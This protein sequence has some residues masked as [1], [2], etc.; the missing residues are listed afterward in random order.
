M[1]TPTVRRRPLRS[2][3]DN[4]NPATSTKWPGIT[5]HTVYLPLFLTVYSILELVTG[6]LLLAKLQQFGENEFVCLPGPNVVLGPDQSLIV[7][8][9]PLTIL[10]L[11]DP[12]HQAKPVTSLPPPFSL[13]RNLGP[14]YHV[15]SC[16]LLPICAIVLSATLTAMHFRRKG[17][18]A[19]QAMLGGTILMAI[20]GVLSWSEEVV[21]LDHEYVVK[22]WPACGVEGYEVDK[23]WGQ[24]MARRTLENIRE[25][26]LA[27]AVV[28]LIVYAILGIAAA[29]YARKEAKMHATRVANLPPTAPPTSSGADT[30]LRDLSTTSGSWNPRANPSTHS[31][32]TTPSNSDSRVL[33]THEPPAF[34]SPSP[35]TAIHPT[36][37]EQA[38]T[39]PTTRVESNA[40]REVGDE[41]KNVGL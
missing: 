27:I 9:L 8:H 10:P 41:E 28:S 26:G 40:Q 23:L 22:S 19:G 38:A 7:K 3:L 6:A 18:T 5:R 34:S 13:D 36:L 37:R 20:F 39:M 31:A 24:R 11:L 14:F 29:H 2:L 33:A 4:P 21:S 25:W 12:N 1:A 17:I 15:L 30:E 16:I 32:N 35:P